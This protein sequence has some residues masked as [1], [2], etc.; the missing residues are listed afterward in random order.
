MDSRDS[1]KFGEL[2]DFQP[3]P[4]RGDPKWPEWVSNLFM[5]FFSISHPGVK[6]KNLK[7]WKAKDLGDFW[8][9]NMRV[10]IWSKAACH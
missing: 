3:E 9:G 7:K 10:N 2:R 1:R 5:G 4:Y 6:M 8:D